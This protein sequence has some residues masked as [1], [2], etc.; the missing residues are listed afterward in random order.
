MPELIEDGVTGALVSSDDVDEL[1][2]AIVRVLGDDEIYRRCEEDRARAAAY[3][4]WDRAADDVLEI[5][6]GAL[7]RSG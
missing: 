1:C 5:V 7:D 2:S 3:Y 4:T 6:H